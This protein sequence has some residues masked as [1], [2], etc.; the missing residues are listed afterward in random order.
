MSSL[1]NYINNENDKTFNLFVK[2]NQISHIISDFYYKKMLLFIEI[3][4]NFYL[5]LGRKDKKHWQIIFYRYSHDW[6]MMSFL[7]N[8]FYLRDN[9]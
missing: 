9:R 6:F 5:A 4:R 8:R 2:G 7:Q 3:K 1:Y